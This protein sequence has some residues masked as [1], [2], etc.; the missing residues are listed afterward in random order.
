MVG[1]WIIWL[2]IELWLSE[3]LVFCDLISC[4]IFVHACV[5]GACMHVY[6]INGQWKNWEGILVV[7]CC[8]SYSSV[9]TL[10]SNVRLVSRNLLGL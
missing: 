10:Y 9:I 2:H 3:Q 1:G 4:C 5:R 6:L 8:E 7:S